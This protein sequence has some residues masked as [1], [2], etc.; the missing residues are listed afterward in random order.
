MPEHYC[1]M[2]EPV[3]AKG[4]PAWMVQGSETPMWRRWSEALSEGTRGK[5]L[6]CEIHNKEVVLFNR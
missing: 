6:K 4:L 2:K 1:S 3:P 5:I